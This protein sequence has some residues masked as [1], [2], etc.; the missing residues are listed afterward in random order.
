MK[1]CPFCAEEIQDAAI[2]CRFCQRA[3]TESGAAVAT[4]PMTATWNPGTAAVLSFFF[5]GLGQLYKGRIGLGFLLFCGTVL[6]YFMLI[7]PG[8]I[9]HIYTI[10][11]AYNGR[12]KGAPPPPRAITPR[13]PPTAEQIAAGRKQVK[14][15]VAIVVALS[16]L[17]V[18]TMILV[19]QEQTRT[20]EA[21]I[22]TEKFDANRPIFNAL[23]IDDREV[24]ARR[25]KKTP[26]ELDAIEAIGRQSGWGSGDDS[27][28]RDRLQVVL[29]TAGHPCGSV[30]SAV[31]KPGDGMNY[32]GV[33]CSSGNM[34]VLKL[35]Q[36]VPPEIVKCSKTKTSADPFQA[37]GLNR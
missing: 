21:A 8:V 1:N 31:H 17:A 14:I 18:L 19:P 16:V 25:Y 26:A 30:T 3:V 20:R 27:E 12:P 23:Q 2:V 13:Q 9:L 35:K 24:V 29:F 33:R 34:F 28:W 11:D 22:A 32:W 6:G 36:G 7:V 37:C 10:V 4:A 15:A 5:P